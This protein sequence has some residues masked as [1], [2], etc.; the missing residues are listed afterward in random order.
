VFPP[1]REGKKQKVAETD[2]FLWVLVSG[3]DP[4]EFFYLDEERKTKDDRRR[5]HYR[6]E[7]TPLSKRE[8]KNRAKYC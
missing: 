6:R 5:P 4:D 7:N 8:M 2:N 3:Y 1:L